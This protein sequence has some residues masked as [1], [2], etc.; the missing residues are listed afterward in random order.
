MNEQTGPQVKAPLY[1]DPLL[2]GCVV[3]LRT[4]AAHLFPLKETVAPK[5]EVDLSVHEVPGIKSAKGA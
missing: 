2:V 3:R 1:L 4:S 5:C